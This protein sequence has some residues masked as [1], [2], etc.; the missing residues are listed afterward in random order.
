MTPLLE[1]PGAHTSPSEPPMHSSM[2]R[3]GW[4]FLKPTPRYAVNRTPRC[5]R[6][7]NPLYSPSTSFLVT[8]S[9][10]LSAISN[11][12]RRMDKDTPNCPERE[13]RRPSEGVIGS[14]FAL[15]V[16]QR[17]TSAGANLWR[18]SWM[19][20][21]RNPLCS[22]ASVTTPFSSLVRDVFLDTRLEAAVHPQS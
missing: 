5:K 14:N 7:G 10:Y 12:F 20:G 3:R 8:G 15:Q 9:T 13:G 16:F 17:L 11:L 21:T 19:T 22:P 4:I 1:S 6:I 18:K 2:S